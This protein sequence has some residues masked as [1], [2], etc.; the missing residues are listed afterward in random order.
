MI[1]V[2]FLTFATFNFF[3]PGNVCHLKLGF[4]A[5]DETVKACEEQ[6]GLD[7][8]WYEQYFDWLVGV[9]QGDFGTSLSEGSLPVTTELERRLPVTLELMFLTL[10]FALILGIPPGVLSAVRPNTPTDWISRM[11]S[12]IWLSIPN[13]YLGIL[14]ITFAAI[15]FGW[16]PPQFGQSYVSFFDDPLTNLEEF[17]LPSLILAV[18]TAAVIMR[19]TRSAMLEVM[20]NDY[21]RT[22]WSKGLRERTVVWRH[23][24]KNA[25]IP[26]VTVVGLQIGALIGGAVLIES[27]FNLNGIGKYVLEAIVR[28]DFFI[29][30]SMV[31]MFAAVY[32]IANLVVDITYAWL[33]PRIHYG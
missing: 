5:T 8:P 30:Q 22:A 26:V 6:H 2:S 7:R 15:W 29:V 12:V 4:G 1:G 21:I 3:I 31:L 20:R 13:F 14:V 27:V 32:V 23:A 24:L 9:P 25:M 10:F 16:T 33:D 11:L 19:L 18:G 17:L 28:R